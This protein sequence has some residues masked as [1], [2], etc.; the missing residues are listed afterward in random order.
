MQ[1][2]IF[3]EECGEGNLR[4]RLHEKLSGP[5]AFARPFAGERYPGLE[6]CDPPD[7]RAEVLVLRHA[8]RPSIRRAF[9]NDRSEPRKAREG[10]RLVDTPEMFLRSVDA[11]SSRVAIWT[12]PWPN[13]RSSYHPP[14]SRGR[15]AKIP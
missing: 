7:P 3:L 2:S 11:R 9:V 8:P 15:S 10:N 1:M 4:T 12:G 6:P 13:D 5:E 14:A